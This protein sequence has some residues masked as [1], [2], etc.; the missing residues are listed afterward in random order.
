[1]S[2]ITSYRYAFKETFRGFGHRKGSYLFTVLLSALA[3][4]IP[5]FISIVFYGLSEPFRQLPTAI[6]MTVFTAPNSSV[7]RIEQEIQKIKWVVKTEIVT[8]EEAFQNLNESLGIRQVKTLKN[9]LPDLIIVTINDRA[10]QKVVEQIAQ[11]IEDIKGVDFVPYEAGWHEKF[12]AIQKTAIVGLSCL[13][14]VVIGLALL[15]LMHTM[16]LTSASAKEEL[17]TLYL[18]GASPFFA[19]RPFAWRGALMMMSASLLALLLTQ[20]G[21]LIFGHS[22]NQAASLYHTSV[23]IML[24][25]WQWCLGLIVIFSILGAAVASG[26]AVSMWRKLE[27]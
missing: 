27:H 12:L 5:L 10:Q 9:P 22:V 4:T 7:K 15:V 26:T 3:I 13:G 11:Q 8:K 25:T 23:N 2:Y 1:M 24:P 20:I 18:F 21:V 16:R 17:K 19:I 6:E 14:L